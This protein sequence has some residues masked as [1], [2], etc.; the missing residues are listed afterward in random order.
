MNVRSLYRPVACGLLLTALFAFGA[1]IASPRTRWMEDRS[2]ALVI[3]LQRIA[4]LGQP[5]GVWER[6][7][8][9]NDW[10][11]LRRFGWGVSERCI[12][13][14]NT[15]IP[16]LMEYRSVASGFP[17]VCLESDVT[18]SPAG[19]PIPEPYPLAPRWRGVLGNVFVLSL[20][21]HIALRRFSH[22]RAMRW[23]RQGK[24]SQCGYFLSKVSATCS[25]CGHANSGAP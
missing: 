22:H 25:E 1:P 4:W 5:P 17:F 15:M 19:T 11:R 24:C 8:H 21:S 9:D 14:P 7:S 3:D 20:A 23:T 18:V 2:S 10:D 16:R 13:G 12:G 6:V